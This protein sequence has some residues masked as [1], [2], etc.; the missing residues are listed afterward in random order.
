MLRESAYT[1]LRIYATAD[2]IEVD[3]V[4]RLFS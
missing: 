3:H 2:V 4:D 1:R